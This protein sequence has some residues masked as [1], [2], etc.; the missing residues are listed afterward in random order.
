MS[1]IYQM[2]GTE[3]AKLANVYPIGQNLLTEH[4]KLRILIGQFCIDHMKSCV[5]A[6][7]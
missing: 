6:L 7:V 2:K 3:S 5:V 4:L 1:Q